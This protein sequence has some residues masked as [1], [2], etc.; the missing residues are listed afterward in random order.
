MTSPFPQSLADMDQTASGIALFDDDTANKLDGVTGQGTV[1]TIYRDDIGWQMLIVDDTL[2]EFW[3]RTRKP[4]APHWRNWRKFVDFHTLNDAID[5]AVSAADHVDAAEVRRL[6]TEQGTSKAGARDA[7]IATV[8]S[9]AISNIPQGLDRIAVETIADTRLDNQLDDERAARNDAITTAVNTSTT[10]IIAR[11]KGA[12]DAAII[13]ER[14]AIDRLVNS[15]TATIDATVT[16][17]DADLATERSE[18]MAADTAEAGRREAAMTAEAAAR[19]H[20]V[21]ALDTKLTGDIAAAERRSATKLETA[22][23]AEAAQRST[24]IQTKIGEA[25]ARELAG[26]QSWVPVMRVVTRGAKKILHV[27]DWSGGTGRKPTTG[28]IGQNGIVTSAAQAA[29]ISVAVGPQGPRGRDGA[30]A[31]REELQRLNGAIGD[32]TQIGLSHPTVIH[33]SN[34]N[35]DWRRLA[36]TKASLVKASGA[37]SVGDHIYTYD[38]RGRDGT[39]SDR[40]DRGWTGSSTRVTCAG[41]DIRALGGKEGG[42]TSC[43][44]LLCNQ[45]ANGGHGIA[46]PSGENG[47][48]LV[49]CRTANVRN[50]TLTIRRRSGGY[51]GVWTWV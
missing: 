24:E 18:R 22:I 5:V 29:D 39:R 37:G 19:E 49:S 23:T 21:R 45:S 13:T 34:S 1:N 9:T 20:T 2:R 47:D 50:Q 32:I 10:G 6:I 46:A 27:S 3:Q 35:R 40:T 51:V 8:V 33:I 42:R 28:Y 16:A 25:A 14:A 48:F 38:T 15:K 4:A 41:F 12:I 43:G 36:G 7:A 31:P 30:P 11:R 17:P 44:T 26:L